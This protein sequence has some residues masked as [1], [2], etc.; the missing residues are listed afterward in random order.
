[1]ARKSHGLEMTPEQFGA[2]G[3]CTSEQ[4]KSVFDPCSDIAARLVEAEKRK[5]ERQAAGG[6]P[7][8]GGHRGC[9]PPP[10][11]RGGKYPEGSDL[12]KL[13][14]EDGKIKEVLKRRGY[15][16]SSA[17]VDWINF[18]VGV[19]TFE[20]DD[21]TISPDTILHES[22]KLV[23]VTPDEIMICISRRLQGIIGYG[24]SSMLGYGQHFYDQSY[25][26][27]DGWGTV[28]VG[29]QNQTVLVSLSGKGIAAAKDGWELRLKTFLEQSQR[30]RITRL[31]LAHD[32]YIG[33]M[34]SVDKADEDH[35]N[36]LFNCGG[37]NPRC[38]YRGDW[39]NPDGKGRSFYVG[40]RKNGKFCRV[41]EKGRELGS[42]S[43]DW[44][45]VEVEF[46]SVD[47]VIPFDALIRPGE[48]LAAAYPAFGW[49]SEHQERILTTQKETQ[50]GVSQAIK[51]MRHQCGAYVHHL[52]QLLG[53]DDFI[54]KVSRDD[55]EPK[56]MKL[57]HHGLAPA[58]IHQVRYQPPPVNLS[59]AVTAW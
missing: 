12:V 32:D 47:R 38:E 27:G 33:A 35:T 22:E 3:R 36:G 9:L 6:S 28:S 52:V 25:T 55:K 21:C 10:A 29:G 54:T 5:A 44:V 31:D 34:Y 57:P 20:S 51:W 59:A 50:A 43:S 1:M 24:V 40:N 48:Y 2:F 46:K 42:P 58:S 7:L 4:I 18:T 15:G 13:V 39:K 26:L 45:R 23:P 8:A 14:L 19:E 37:R 30:A 11:N 49:I 41:Y 17:L 56:F 16:G 53:V